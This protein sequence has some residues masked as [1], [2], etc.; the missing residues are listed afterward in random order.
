MQPAAP[1][2]NDAVPLLT[3]QPVLF[4][5]LG[6]RVQ[7]PHLRDRC[8]TASAARPQRRHLA[9]CADARCFESPGDAEHWI[10]PFHATSQAGWKLDYDAFSLEI[11]TVAAHILILVALPISELAQR[12]GGK[13]GQ[14]D[15]TGQGNLEG[16]TGVAAGSLR[17]AW[18][19]ALLAVGGLVFYVGQSIALFRFGIA[20][21]EGITMGNKH[22]EV[23][24]GTMLYDHVSA[25]MYMSLTIGL[26]LGSV[27]GR[28]LLAGL[29]CTSFTIFLL[30]VLLTA[31][32]FIPPFFVS[33]YWI[34][35][36]FE[37]ST[38]QKDCQ[39]VF[40]DSDDFGFARTACDIRTGTYIAAIILLLVAALGPVVIGLWDYSRVVCLPRR[41]AW[42]DMPDYWRSLAE[43]V[44]KLA[45][46]SCHPLLTCSVSFVCRQTQ[47]SKPW[48]RLRVR[49]TGPCS[50]S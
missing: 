38:G 35:W 29:S 24:I 44:R 9:H 12:G 17:S 49:T 45:N 43:P 34:F 7:A 25:V 15:R 3:A 22:N 18:W 1:L 48:R 30:W 19:F 26:A 50:R 32:A 10:K 41:R 11:I 27:I 37:D 47:S 46:N 6:S 16:F 4:S 13:G 21:A 39:S 36:A 5:G 40:G 14:R 8:A 2:P 33:T 42:V 23:A 20:W 31:G 28:W